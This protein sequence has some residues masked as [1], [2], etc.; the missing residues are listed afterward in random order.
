MDPDAR[1]EI[2][3]VLEVLPLRLDPADVLPYSR[4]RFAWIS[5]EP[6]RTEGCEL[7]QR[8][9]FV[10]VTMTATGVAE[11]QWIQP[12][13]NRVDPSCPLPTFMKSIKREQPPPVPAGLR[14]T[15]WDAQGRWADDEFRFPPYQYKEQFMLTD[16]TVLRYVSSGEREIL[17]GFGAQHTRFC[18]PASETKKNPV[19]YEDERLSLIGDSFCMLSFGWVAGL[20]CRAARTLAGAQEI[21]DL[22][23][24]APGA[25][26]RA[27][28]SAPMERWKHYGFEGKDDSPQDAEFLVNKLALGANHTG[29]DVRI[30]TGELMTP[31]KSVRQS[32]EAIWWSWKQVFS[33]KWQFQHHINALEMRALLLGLQWRAQRPGHLGKKVVH[34]VDGVR[35]FSEVDGALSDWIDLAWGQGLPLGTI[36]DALSGMQHLW[37]QC[38][39]QLHHSW[40]LFR[41]WRKIEPPCR[42]PPLPARLASA[43]LAWCIFHDELALGVMV[44]LGFHCLLRTG[45]LLALRAEDVHL[46]EKAAI[47][48]LRLTKSGRRVNAFEA[49][50]VSDR[51]VLAAL[52]TLLQIRES[53]HVAGLL[54]PHSTFLLQHGVSLEQ[55]LL[56]GRWQS[57]STARIYL[58][59]GLATLASVK[60]SPETEAKA[61]SYNSSFT[62][63]PW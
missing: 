41:A 56:R 26:S 58:Q 16:D 59:D 25:C 39:R 20:L 61:A 27:G 3:S 57:L 11:A 1:D 6:S 62:A 21:V 55:I 38:R 7:V 4:P 15:P 24:L 50:T 36:G 23:G 14:R 46:S 19:R 22:M 5:E 45:E 33:K 29:S 2:S 48:N 54:W 10:E 52:R 17:M 42:A 51:G 8:E 18:F 47:L 31:S 32:T 49:V 35:S 37:P 28:A 43:F 60:C 53:Q 12:G 9:G 44:G 40:R 63:T 34:L 13:W 30:T